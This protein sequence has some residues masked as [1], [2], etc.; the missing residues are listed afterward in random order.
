M[1]LLAACQLGAAR[2]R[3]AGETVSQSGGWETG[4]RSWRRGA[5]EGEKLQEG[6]AGSVMGQPDTPLQPEQQP[7]GDESQNFPEKASVL[8]CNL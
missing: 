1:R 5:K 4:A 2:N 3:A 8:R 6:G 7:A